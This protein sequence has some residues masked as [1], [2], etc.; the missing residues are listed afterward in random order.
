MKLCIDC[1]YYG[2][3]QPDRDGPCAKPHIPQFGASLMC[4][5]P[6]TDGEVSPVDGKPSRFLHETLAYKQRLY[7]HW[8]AVIAGRCGTRARHFEAKEAD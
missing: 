3:K 4:T 7:P 2:V 1:R 5:H 6:S 8:I